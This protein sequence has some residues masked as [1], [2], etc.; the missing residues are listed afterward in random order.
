MPSQQPQDTFQVNTWAT[1]R[2]A[3]PEWAGRSLM[4]EL[5]LSA[6]A[7]GAPISYQAFSLVTHVVMTTL[8]ECC[9]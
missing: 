1:L 6:M 5:G 8:L 3:R 9:N 4:E 7:L 2:A